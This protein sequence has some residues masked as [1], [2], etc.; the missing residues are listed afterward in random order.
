[1]LR[2]YTRM[3]ISQGLT[4]LF[5]ALLVGCQPDKSPKHELYFVEGKIL[6]DGQPA[7]GA[8]IKFNLQ[9]N[10]NSAA[11]RS[12][13]A[14]VKEDGS[15]KA[16]TFDQEDG[17][18]P[19]KYDAYLFWLEIPKDGGMMIDRLQGRFMDPSKPIVSFEVS[20]ANIHIGTIQLSTAATVR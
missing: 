19:G 10:K 18:P 15:F 14:L 17:L 11:Q 12:S 9:G 16:S 13:G 8:S 4:L 7:M 20:K 2:S 5:V 6:I 3:T 1:M